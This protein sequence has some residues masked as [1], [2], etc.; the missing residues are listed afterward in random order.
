LRQ[1][2]HLSLR[3]TKISWIFFMRF[4]KYLIWN[5]IKK[6]QKMLTHNEINCYWFR[7]EQVMRSQCKAMS[8]TSFRSLHD[9]LSKPYARIFNIANNWCRN[10]IG[11]YFV[12][13]ILNKIWGTLR[14]IF[15]LSI[16]STLFQYLILLNKKIFLSLVNNRTLF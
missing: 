15:I 8:I 9:I 16:N 3:A 13:V 6:F 10:R 14:Y 4:V 7:T 5:S 12:A 2:A 11:H 1:Y